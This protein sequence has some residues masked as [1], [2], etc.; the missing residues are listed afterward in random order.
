MVFISDPRHGCR[1]QYL[2]HQLLAARKALPSLHLEITGTACVHSTCK[3]SR[4]NR[5]RTREPT[6][7][8]KRAEAPRM[9]YHLPPRVTGESQPT[10]LAD[11]IE[12]LWPTRRWRSFPPSMS[13]TA[14]I[15]HVGTSPMLKSWSKHRRHACPVEPRTA[16][17]EVPHS[18]AA[19]IGSGQGLLPLYQPDAAHLE[20]R[21]LEA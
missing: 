17:P 19:I 7:S 15:P 18:D 20:G 13:Q 1:S 2:S 11:L 6:N 21:K 14:S 3:T 10:H 12:L 5:L 9:R 8:D 4:T 16:D